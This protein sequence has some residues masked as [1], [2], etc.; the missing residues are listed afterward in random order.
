MSNAIT[1]IL[2][3]DDEEA[4]CETLSYI[5]EEKGYFVEIADAGKVAIEKIKKTPYNA[6]LIDL[7]L[8]DMNGLDILRQFKK[9]DPDVICFIIT[10]NATVQNAINALEEGADGY[11]VKPTPINE[12]LHQLQQSLEKQKLQKELKKSEEEFRKIFEVIPDLFLLISKDTTILDYKGK[13]EHFPIPLKDIIG[14]KL[15]ELLPSNF[16]D[17]IMNIISKNMKNQPQTL[18]FSLPINNEIK[19]YETWVTSFSADRIAIF[20]RDITQRKQ[21]EKEMRIKDFAINSSINGIVIANLDGN[22][23]YVNQACLDLWGYER[24][25]ELIGRS[26]LKFKYDEKK[27]DKIK[28]SLNKKGNWRGEVI[29][30]RKDGSLFDAILSLNIITDGAGNPLSMMG[31]FI[32]I[33]ERKRSEKELAKARDTLADQVVEKTWQILEEKKIKELIINTISDGILVLDES[34]KLYLKNDILKN[35][36][37]ELFQHDLYEGYDFINSP[38]NI[39]DKTVRE[40][41]KSQSSKTITIEPKPS[42]HLQFVTAGKDIKKQTSI[43]T[44]IEV[45]DVSQFIEFD[46]MR[47]RFVSTAS[48]ELR[49]PISVIIQSIRNLRNYGNQ[50]SKKQFETLMKIMSQNADLLAELVDDLLVISR[51]DEKRIKLEWTSYRPS[52]LIYNVLTQLEPRRMEKEIVIEVDLDKDVKLNGD[53][54]K[55]SQIFRI[56]IDN[57]IKY[58]NKNSKLKISMINNYRG[59]Y[60]PQGIDGVLIEFKDSGIGIRATELPFLFNRFFRSKEVQDIPGT[61]L[62]LSIARDLIKLHKG[63][64]FVN[65]VFGQ[66]STFSVFLPRL[67]KKP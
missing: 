16:T 67:E 59:E 7:K 21:A 5:F 42:I 40:L 35:F 11:F 64:V 53:P 48:H 37:W 58:S 62:G 15:T 12:L 6:A 13:K 63:D 19:Y 51:I 26:V 60:N 44:I 32:D 14:K 41:F 50:M 45:R 33:T 24:A 34:G 8:P 17:P 39:F 30:E 27:F 4:I 61:G 25:D 49:T 23:E 54:K 66:G 3:V 65:S 46:N 10:G 9:I 38:Q 29:A 47:K 57:A 2:I 31:S 20:I 1:K 55:I 22:I 36:Y 28:T 43:G 52:G 18:E 56:F